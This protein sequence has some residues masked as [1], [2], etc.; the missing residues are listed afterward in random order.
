[1][2]LSLGEDL[3]TCLLQRNHSLDCHILFLAPVAAYSALDLNESCTT[4]HHDAT[5]HTRLSPSGTQWS[6]LF[7]LLSSADKAEC[8]VEEEEPILH[9][10]DMY[11]SNRF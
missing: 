5:Y 6:S 4:C 10:L 2:L 11:R 9:E 1:M 7:Y 8:T 3:L